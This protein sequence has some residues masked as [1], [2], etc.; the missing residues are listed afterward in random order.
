[1]I[2][3]LGSQ[4][5]VLQSGLF[6]QL[7]SLE[8]S[9]MDIFDYVSM[10]GVQF[11]VI[12]LEPPWSLS[13]NS[14]S[15]GVM[16]VIEKGQCWFEIPTGQRPPVLIKERGI[17]ALCGGQPHILRDSL[18]TEITKSIAQAPVTDLKF[19]GDLP[20]L[21][22]LGTRIFSARLP[23][24]SA[25]V[26]G[27]Y[28]AWACIPPDEPG[29]GQ[30]IHRLVPLIENEVVLHETETGTNSIARRLTECTVIAMLRYLLQSGE[31]SDPAW[32]ASSADRHVTRAL[33]LIHENPEVIWSVEEL[34]GAVGMGR[35][36][37]YDRFKSIVGKTPIHYVTELRIKRAAAAIQQGRLSL[38]EIAISVGYE[39]EAAFNRAFQRQFGMT[40][41]RYRSMAKAIS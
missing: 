16:Y 37:F 27:L 22:P 21:S 14:E 8:R 25:S 9:H 33:T 40:P 1:M 20:P 28:P 24:S 11:G 26:G 4:I 38:G 2:L 23:I 15:S 39:S 19:R 12:A 34:A 36:A 5:I 17:F 10:E 7:S 3:F 31:D 35:S 30:L 6:D 18:D 29:S 13:M 41:G 32:R